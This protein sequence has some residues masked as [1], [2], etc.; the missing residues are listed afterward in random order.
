MTNFFQNKS[1][2]FL[3]SMV[4]LGLIFFPSPQKTFSENGER[5]REIPLGQISERIL[6]INQ[7]MIDDTFLMKQKYEEMFSPARRASDLALKCLEEETFR[8]CG[9][10]GGGNPCKSLGA[11]NSRTNTVE[12][13]KNFI[14]SKGL[15]LTRNIEELDNLKIKIDELKT[16]LAEWNPET[17]FLLS[18]SQARLIGFIDLENCQSENDY[19]ICKIETE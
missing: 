9:C 19:Y 2:F 13:L 17:E 11:I 1:K 15:K 5:C 8:Y 14:Q 10:C 12:S 3:L 4:I 6:E 18:C 7:E 16:A